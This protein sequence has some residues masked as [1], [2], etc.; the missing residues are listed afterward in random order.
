MTIKEHPY[1][2]TITNITCK[3]SDTIC[4]SLN[5]SD[6]NSSIFSNST[7]TSL[8]EINHRQ[9][10]SSTTHDKSRSFLC[11]Q[12]SSQLNSMFSSMCLNDSDLHD[13][14]NDSECCDQSNVSD[15]E[16]FSETNIPV[17]YTSTYVTSITVVEDSNEHET[18]SLP[19]FSHIGGLKDELQSVKCF[20][21]RFLNSEISMHGK[22][23]LLML[24]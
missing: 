9:L 11:N 13:S 12:S 20:I 3:E 7:N 14:K 10:Y 6:S 2:F 17:F 1:D 22:L 19:C 21:D 8:T 18:R 4:D 5:I 23:L 24:D 15:M 16:L